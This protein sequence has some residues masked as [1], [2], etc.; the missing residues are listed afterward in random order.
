MKKL[1]VAID[2]A[3]HEAI[4]SEATATG[5]SMCQIIRER[6]VR[7]VWLED[8]RRVVREE[9]MRQGDLNDAYTQSLQKLIVQIK[10]NL[11]L[12]DLHKEAKVNK[13]LNKL[14]L[15]VAVF[16]MIVPEGMAMFSVNE[17]VREY[18]ISFESGDDTSF[19]VKG[20]NFKTLENLASMN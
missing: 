11:F 12:L 7:D 2:A 17:T 16:L 13:M 1:T 20:W 14:V 4:R 15:V 18:R 9:L 3:T 5:R 8:F 19:I 6:L 10:T